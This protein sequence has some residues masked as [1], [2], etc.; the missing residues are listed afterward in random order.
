MSDDNRM[1]RIIHY[2]I[3]IRL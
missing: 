1:K 3:L 2:M